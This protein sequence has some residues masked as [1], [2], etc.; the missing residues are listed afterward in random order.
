[1]KNFPALEGPTS[2]DVNGDA[3]KLAY[4]IEMRDSKLHLPAN[5]LAGG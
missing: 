4:I 1:M 3:L 5:Y 2:F